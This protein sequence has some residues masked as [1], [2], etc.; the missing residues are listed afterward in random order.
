MYKGFNEHKIK[1]KITEIYIKEHVVL[2]DTEDLEMVKLKRWF[3]SSKPIYPYCDFNSNKK[4]TRIR[5][6]HFLIGKPPVGMVVDHIDGNKLNNTKSNLRLSDYSLNSRNCK[7]KKIS[8]DNGKGRNLKRFVV[9][10]RVGG[11][12]ILKRFLTEEEAI[13]FR[14]KMEIE[15]L[16]F[17]VNRN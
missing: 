8:Y 6:H 16:G 17:I 1:D 14:N 15:S 5:L 12:K 2:I 10:M 3:I 7:K 4:R 9:Q 13:V 11:K